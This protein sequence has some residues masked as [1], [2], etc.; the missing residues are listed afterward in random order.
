IQTR[1]LRAADTAVLVD[2]MRFRDAASTQG[3]ATSFIE[4]MTTTDTE[5]IEFLRGSGSSLYGSNAVGGVINITSRQGG[6]APRGEFRTEG[7]GLGMIRS[8]IGGSGGVA[9]DRFTYSGALSHLNVTKGVRD[10]NPYRNTSVQGA[11][12]HTV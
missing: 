2:G 5:R 8:V 9:D 12:R 1:G 4:S 7:G 10:G 11:V 6:G 3:D